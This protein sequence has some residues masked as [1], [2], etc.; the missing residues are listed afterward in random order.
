MH[1]PPKGL[2]TPPKG[3]HTPPKI[4][5]STASS[6]LSS[7]VSS[8]A[9]SVASSAMSSPAGPTA[10]PAPNLAIT[11]DL[12]GDDCKRV[13]PVPAFVI[14]KVSIGIILVHKNAATGALEVAVV[15]KRYSYAFADFVHGKYSRS[16]PR[17]VAA[18]LNQMTTEELLDVFALS[19]EQLWFRVWLRPP[20]L[21]DEKY[22]KKHAKWHSTFIRPDKG[23]ALRAQVKQARG[24]NALLWE[25]PRGHPDAGETDLYCGIRE[26]QEETGI[27]KKDY[28]LVP[29]ATRA[30]SH[31]DMGVRYICRYFVAIL[32]GAW[33]PDL[34]ARPPAARA[35]ARQGEIGEA[36]WMS[37]VDVRAVSSAAV[38]GHLEALVAPVFSLVRRRR[39]LRS[40]DEPPGRKIAKRGG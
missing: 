3:V 35:L 21:A 18:L 27:P 16:R 13:A 37:I 15:R 5:S 29:G 38:N 26:L 11:A 10:K 14:T 6:A 9:S 34:A 24:R 32:P 17:S 25:V 19:F 8:A 30:T 22:V 7:T 23:A 2:Y 39:L 28:R 33:A 31:V 12:A 36:R 1:T 4:G 20:D 40:P